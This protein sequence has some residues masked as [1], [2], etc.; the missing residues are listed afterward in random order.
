MPPWVSCVWQR[1][2]SQT[3]WFDPGEGG[4]TWGESTDGKGGGWPV[5][6]RALRGPEVSRG[7]WE[8]TAVLLGGPNPFH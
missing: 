2:G 6:V 7:V 5:M 8:M 1:P 3:R 4:S